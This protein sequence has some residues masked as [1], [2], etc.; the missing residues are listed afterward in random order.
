MPEEV[1]DDFLPLFVVDRLA[2]SAGALLRDCRFEDIQLEFDLDRPEYRQRVRLARSERR[3]CFCG[4]GPHLRSLAQRIVP[5][6]FGSIAVTPNELKALD[7]VREQIAT[8]GI[9][10]TY[11]ELSGELGVTKQGAMHIVDRL[12]REG[13]LRKTP[14]RTRGIRL[15]DVPDLRAVPAAALTAELARRGIT[16][17]ALDAPSRRPAQAGDVH[18]AHDSC[19]LTVERGH[20]YCRGHWFALPQDLRLRLVDA[21]RRRDHA[22]YGQAFSEAQLRLDGTWRGA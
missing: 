13:L 7:L 20:L 5:S 10:P 17:A 22:A 15:A 6:V 14:A 4:I 2:G 9:A 12:A 8:S 18:C 11:E 21:H 3:G 16:L 1:D 19:D